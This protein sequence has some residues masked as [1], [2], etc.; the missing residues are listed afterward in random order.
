[1]R[2]FAL[3]YVS[4]VL[5]LVLI[6]LF[7]H[8]FQNCMCPNATRFLHVISTCYMDADQTK[9]EKLRRRRERERAHRAAKTGQEKE[10]R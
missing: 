2:R 9:A 5:V 3:L 6:I 10:E 1:M 7:S 4:Y 8:L